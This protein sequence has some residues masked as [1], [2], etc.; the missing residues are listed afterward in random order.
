MLR[1]GTD[2]EFYLAG[3]FAYYNRLSDILTPGSLDFTL[4]G[5]TKVIDE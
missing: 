3:N 2:S 4:D 1:D 5:A